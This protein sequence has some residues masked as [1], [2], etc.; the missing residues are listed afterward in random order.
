MFGRKRKQATQ[1]KKKKDLTREDVYTK[2]IFARLY[3]KMNPG[4]Y[5]IRQDF[6]HSLFLF[7][8]FVLIVCS[9]FAISLGITMKENSKREAELTIPSASF[10][11]GQENNIYELLNE[12]GFVDT[13]INSNGDIIAYG[14]QEMVEA[15]KDSYYKKNVDDIIYLIESNDFTEY[16]IEDIDISD[17]YKTLTI[18]TYLYATNDLDLLKSILTDDISD[19]IRILFIWCGMVNNGEPMTTEFVNVF[20]TTDGTKG[21]TYYT[22][23]RSSAGG[24]IGDIETQIRE[25]SNNAEDDTNSENAESDNSDSDISAEENK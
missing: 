1:N 20:D 5:T 12:Y 19:M 17:D 9:I 24:I 7:I 23:Q 15:Y 18:S 11:S 13:Q 4:D 10:V 3:D 14:T 8:I 21:T 16:G 25:Q 22:T 2:P 6:Y